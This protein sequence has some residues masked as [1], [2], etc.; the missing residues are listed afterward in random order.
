MIFY[1]KNKYRN[2]ETSTLSSLPPLVVP[3]APLTK[4]PL[5]KSSLAKSSV[6]QPAKNTRPKVKP[7]EK[8]VEKTRSEKAKEEFDEEALEWIGGIISQ[9]FPDVPKWVDYQMFF[10]DLKMRML[11]ELED[12]LQK[13]NDTVAWNELAF[14]L[15]AQSIDTGV[16]DI[17]NIV[18]DVLYWEIPVEV[19][20]LYKEI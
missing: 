3:F 5:A 10:D 13:G 18:L 17:Q 7:A 12:A 1:F 2:V 4:S 8:K 20:Q 9:E 14:P 6:K 15:V 11:E 19:I 16:S